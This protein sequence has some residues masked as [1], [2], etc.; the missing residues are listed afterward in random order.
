MQGLKGFILGN[1]EII[2]LPDHASIGNRGDKES[3]QHI[4][5]Y[6]QKK[7]AIRLIVQSDGLVAIETLLE[8]R[9]KEAQWRTIYRLVGKVSQIVYD[10]V[11][12]GRVVASKHATSNIEGDTAPVDDFREK[13]RKLQDAV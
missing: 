7:K 12:S 8:T 2:T 5:E 3:S 11:K 9:I 4:R 13:L 10:I 1:G 6:M